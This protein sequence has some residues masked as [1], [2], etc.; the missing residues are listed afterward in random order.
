MTVGQKIGIVGLLLTVAGVRWSLEALDDHDLE[1]SRQEAVVE[2]LADVRATIRL[3]REEALGAEVTTTGWP[4]SETDL[5]GLLDDI[6]SWAKVDKAAASSLREDVLDHL[7]DL[8]GDAADGRLDERHEP[9]LA[10]AL[11]RLD[12][13]VARSLTRATIDAHGNV[14]ERLAAVGALGLGLWCATIA[15]ARTR[16]GES[17]VQP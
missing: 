4:N 6:F 1:T 11:L 10:D 17:V 5:A 7:G 15:A 16:P 12:L 13:E 9:E 2:R 8:K 3:Q 14:F